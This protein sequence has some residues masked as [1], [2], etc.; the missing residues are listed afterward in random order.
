MSAREAAGR[1]AQG[2]GGPDKRLDKRPDKRPDKQGPPSSG[3]AGP[4]GPTGGTGE[5][6]PS[7]WSA[8]F[9]RIWWLLV[10]VLA[11]NWILASVLLA[12]TQR[13]TVSYSCLLYTSDAADE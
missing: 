4:G 9:R 12:P 10:L 8:G 5:Q 2:P 13:T 6:A 11:V 7:H 3:P 1:G